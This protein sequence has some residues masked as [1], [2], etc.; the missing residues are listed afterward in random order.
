MKNYYNILGVD[1]NISNEDI[2]KV[3]KD[4]INDIK[5]SN[6]PDAQKVKKLKSLEDAYKFL[7]DYHKR[8][9]LDNYLENN[10][11]TNIQTNLQTNLQTDIISNP[12]DV[13][14]NVNSIFNNMNNFNFDNAK[15]TNTYSKSTSYISKLDDNGNL[16]TEEITKINE[17]GKV[18]ESHKIITKDKDG[19][20][21]IKDVPS[22]KTIK[23]NI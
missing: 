11:S 1:K 19:N 2:K 16:V 20:E 21:I 18:S 12:F 8:R 15:N 3:T 13:F 14:S 5:S 4:L 6:I 7:N 17:N 9:K 23:Y 10:L 22:K